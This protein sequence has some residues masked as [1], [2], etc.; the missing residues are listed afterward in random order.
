MITH[1]APDF[2]RKLQQKL[3][4]DDSASETEILNS[5]QEVLDRMNSNDP[6]RNV[7]SEAMP[8]QSETWMPTDSASK[9]RVEQIRAR[10]SE[11]CNLHGDEITPRAMFDL[12]IG[13]FTGA[14]KGKD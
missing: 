3:G 8:H 10:V 5:V 2:I 4:L 11:L 13:E 7:D 14:K 6:A 1:A 9:S 12:I